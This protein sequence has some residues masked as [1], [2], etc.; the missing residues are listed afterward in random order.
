[1]L[2]RLLTNLL[3]S[4]SAVLSISCSGIRSTIKEGYAYRMDDFS[5]TTIV[6][7]VLRAH[8]DNDRMQSGYGPVAS[9]YDR[10]LTDTQ[11][12]TVSAIP[13]PR[14]NAYG[15]EVTHRG[16]MFNGPAKAGRIYRAVVERADLAGT[17]VPLK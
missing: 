16:T 10:S 8:I 11:T 4:L 13:V 9:G 14:L 7:S 15:F 5:A 17:R 3:L 1:M 2:I 12:Y 6:Q